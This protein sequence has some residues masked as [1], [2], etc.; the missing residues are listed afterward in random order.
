MTPFLNIIAD[1]WRVFQTIV[2]IKYIIYFFWVFSLG[3]LLLRG[4]EILDEV[5]V[6]LGETDKRT[7][8]SRPL[9]SS[10]TRVVFP[11]WRAPSRKKLCRGGMLMRR[12]IIDRNCLPIRIYLS[13]SMWRASVLSE[14]TALTSDL[15][16]RPLFLRGIEVRL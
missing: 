14:T 7:R 15:Y 16:S 12:L 1:K 2:S 3:S 13:I 6:L 9:N 10:D 4:I 5:L 8:P 11:V